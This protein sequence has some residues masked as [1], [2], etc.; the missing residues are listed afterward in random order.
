[1]FTSGTPG[2]VIEA[3]KRHESGEG[4]LV[5]VYEAHGARCRAAI[6]AARP[7]REVIEC[8]L[9]ERPLRPGVSPAHHL[10]AE[11][12]AASHDEPIV[13]DATWHFDLRPYEVRTFH[14]HWR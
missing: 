8:D 6:R 5:R 4:V 11:S 12:A 13:L 1:L 2:V 7:V 10:W 14:I 9:L 3:V